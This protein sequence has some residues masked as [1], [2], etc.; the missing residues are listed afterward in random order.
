MEIQPPID[1]N[2]SAI[3]RMSEVP[4]S[5][6]LFV[7]GSF[8][9]RV[10]VYSQ[11]VR[12]LNLADALAGLGYLDTTTTVAVI[13]AGFGGITIAA[14]LAKMGVEVHTFEKESTSLH[15][16]RNCATRFIH[17]HNYDWPKTK[18]EQAEANL[19]FLSWK[20]DMADEVAKAVGAEWE[21]MGPPAE[22][23]HWDITIKS[24]QS[25]KNGWELEWEEKK[26]SGN[27]GTF[28][29]V[30]LA[31]G[32]GTEKDEIKLDS[33]TTYAYWAD[34]PF[35]QRSTQD[36][37]WFVSGAGDGALTDAIRLCFLNRNHAEALQAVVDA[38]VQTH[39]SGFI[40]HLCERVDNKVAGPELFK[41]LNFVAIAN[42][43]SLRDRPIK[44]NAS[45]ESIFGSA[46]KPAKASVLNR[47]IV[48]MLIKVKRITLVKGKIVPG[49]I[50]GARGAYSVTII[51][52]GKNR[53][54]KPE[55]V[56][57]R[58]GPVPALA[59]ISKLNTR[60]SDSLEELAWAW[61]DLYKNPDESDPTLYPIAKSLQ[62]GRERISPD[63]WDCP[64]LL[65][66]SNQVVSDSHT[67]DALYNAVKAV[68]NQRRIR[69]QFKELLGLERDQYP[70]SMELPVLQA[71]DAVK[72]PRSLGAAVQG[73]C[74]SPLVL[75][76]VSQATP[77]LCFLL[78]I[79]AAVRRGGDHNV[80]QR[81]D[82]ARFLVSAA[83]QSARDQSNGNPGIVWCHGV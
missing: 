9:R 54:V 38:I 24:I 79:R 8:A 64:A 6:G 49:G 3:I 74:R 60:L 52:E 15:L 73:L 80:P 5:P 75:V 56:L 30:V 45:E 22:R 1:S 27:R 63:F 50:T 47:L 26:T 57:V 66:Y 72:D 31:V 19:P 16:Q 13:G 51:N 25:V 23:R 61:E 71:E 82:D 53:T 2:W 21:K 28:S 14:A 55:E 10:T 35:A 40:V 81:K 67:C 18:L 62:F 48:W 32:F 65:I 68:L 39:G 36:H 70:L 33:G 42:R 44:L 11:Q 46:G 4:D 41:G 7:L 37:E 77:E 59:A 58:H 78:G 17:P 12:A 76:D 43:L 34:L 20:A 29:L 69:A 83:F